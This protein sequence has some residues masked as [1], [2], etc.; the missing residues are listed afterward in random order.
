MKGVVVAAA[1]PSFSRS[2]AITYCV[3][4]FVPILRKSSRSASRSARKTAAGVS[5]IAPKL[6]DRV[7]DPLGSEVGCDRLDRRDRGLDLLDPGDEREHHR[8]PLAVPCSW[9]RRANSARS[10][11]SNRSRCSS[12]ESRIPAARGTG[13]TRPADRGTAP[14]C[15]RRHRG[16]GRRLARRGTPTARPSRPRTAPLRSEGSRGRKEELRPEQPDPVGAALGGRSDLRL[17][18]D[19]RRHFNRSAVVGG[20]DARAPPP[21]PIRVGSF[22]GRRVGVDDDS[23]VRSVDEQF[24]AVLDLAKRLADS[25]DRRDRQRPRDDRGVSSSAARDSRRSR[26]PR[27]DPVPRCRSG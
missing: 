19:V 26:R 5:T 21:P 6:G 20:R 15:R 4:S 22:A 7:V 12:S 2:A 1:T 10:C 25:D 23:S 13:S 14:A 18:S 11:V 8:D 24:G 17:A 16:S 3:R 27:L 9:A